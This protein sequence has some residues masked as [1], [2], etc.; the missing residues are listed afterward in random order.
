MISEVKGGVWGELKT[1][2]PIDVYR[3][4]LQKTFVVSL[5][6][7]IAPPPSP[8][9]MN[10][11][12]G[13]GAETTDISSVVR[14]QLQDLNKEIRLAIPGTTDKSSRYHLTDLAARIATALDPKK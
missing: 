11:G 14:A 10:M 1:H 4:D 5:I 9:D 7:I 2:A 12:G 3:R 8:G 13:P 6:N